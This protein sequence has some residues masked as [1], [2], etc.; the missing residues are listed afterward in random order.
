MVAISPSLVDADLLSAFLRDVDGNV[1]TALICWGIVLSA[2]IVLRVPR[3]VLLGCMIAAMA[4]V[5]LAATVVDLA[6]ER[7]VASA[8]KPEPA[9]AKNG[10]P[11]PL[12]GLA[13]APHNRQ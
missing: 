12:R 2:F 10:A 6:P 1:R 8:S 11:M 13:A 3:E 9:P 4:T 7:A 5:G